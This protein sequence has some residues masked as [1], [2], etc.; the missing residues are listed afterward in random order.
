MIMPGIIASSGGLATSFE[1]IATVTVGAGGSATV[2][3]TSIS[4]TYQHLQIRGFYTTSTGGQVVQIRVNGDSVFNYSFHSLIGQGSAASA[5]ATSST[6]KFPIFG[7]QVGTSTT[8]PTVSVVDLLDYQTTSK[9]KTFRSLSGMDA[10]GS[11]EVNFISG[12]WQNTSVVSSIEISP[13]NGAIYF[14]Q[15]S[16]FALYGVK[17]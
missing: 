17:A 10:N 11:G 6:D 1:S 13:Y 5:D 3:F 15:Y 14:K 7:R 4:S 9:Y 2:S 12:L 8:N 16:T